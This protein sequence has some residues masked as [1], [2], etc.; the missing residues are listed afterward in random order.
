MSI[1]VETATIIGVGLLGG[2]LG[3]AMKAAGMAQTVRGV[4]R[5]HSTLDTALAMGAIDECHLD[6]GAACEGADLVVVCT[7]ADLVPAK[8]DEILPHLKP[9][10][11]VTDVASTKGVI[12]SHARDTWPAPCRFIGSHP[13]AGSEQ[14]GPENAQPGLYKGCATIV[15]PLA[16]HHA[17]DAHKAVCSLWHGLGSVV[18]LVEPA[19]HDALVARTSHVPHITASLLAQLADSESDIRAAI[20]KGFRD[21]TRVAAGRPELWRDICLT[22]HEAIASALD[23]MLSL[24]Q[25]VRS[26]V[27]NRDAEKLETFFREGAEARRR[28]LGE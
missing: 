23:E 27:G 5:R 8:L 1:R 10:A 16:D 17:K 13:M 6:A 9:T 22:N 26:W 20:G 15:E 21:T 12:C 25:D 7:P 28:T 24:L 2:S 14:Y 4:G 11:V 18:A 3:L 19:R